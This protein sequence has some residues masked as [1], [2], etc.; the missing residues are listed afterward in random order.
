[1]KVVKLS[2]YACLV[3]AALFLTNAYGQKL[4]EIKFEKYELPNGL[5][6]ILHVDS[7]LP[8][9]SVNIWYHVGSQN[10]KPGRTG[11]AHLFEHMMFQGS[12][13]HNSGY[14]EP[15]ES[16]G[17]TANG[18]TTE[19][20]TNYLENIPSQYLE[21][22]LWLESDRM[23]YLVPAMTQE[24]LD[25]QRDV[26]KNERRERV[27]NQPY[28]KLEEILKSL[29]FPKDH[30]YSW[31]V[32]GSMAD[33]SAASRDDVIEFFQ[34]YYVPNNASL[35]IAGDFDPATAKQLVEKYFGPIPPGPAID[36]LQEWIPEF[37]GIRRAVAEDNV[38]LPQLTMAWHAPQVYK[39][40]DA[41]LD[42]LAAILGSG[43]NSRLYKSLVYD[44][45]IAQSVSVGLVS[46]E[47]GSVFHITATA[48]QGHSLDEIERAIDDEL[49]KL[50]VTGITREEFNLAQTQYEAYF[51]RSLERVG[52]FYGRA[53]L[54]NAYNIRLGDPGRFQWD[55]DRYL[56]TTPAKVMEFAR[57]YIDLNKRGIV[58][59]VP[60]TEVTAATADFDRSIK[61]APGPR[62]AFEPPM[63]QAAT[64]SNG[65]ELYVIERQD[66]PLVQVNLVIKSGFA[67]DPPQLPGLASLT[68]DLLD[69][70]TKSRTSLEISDEARSLGTFLAA[71]S[72]FDMTTVSINAMKKNLDQSLDLLADVTLHPVFPASELERL[73][74]MYLGRIALQAKDPGAQAFKAFYQ[75]L[76]GEG[77]PYAQP[78]TGTGTE[79][80]MNT[81]TLADVT[82]FYRNHYLPNNAVVIVVGDITL[83]A[84]KAELERAFKSWK[85]GTAPKVTI[86][87]PEV[88]SGT[89]I[90]IVDNPGAPQSMV[91]A[92]HLGLAR[93][94]SDYIPASLVNFILGGESIARLYM[95]LRQDKG[96][97]YGA[98][99]SFTSRVGTGAFVA[100]APVQTEVTKET[101]TELIKEIRGICGD[102]AISAEE[103]KASQSYL[104]EQLIQS[105]ETIGAMA[106]QVALQIINGLPMDYWRKYPDV[107]NAVD[108]AA[109]NAMARKLIHPDD[110][111]I[112]VYGDRAKVEAGLRELNVGEVVPLETAG[113]PE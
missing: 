41:E 21:T 4:P 110:L 56:T 11:F 49:R 83:D 106:G 27:E 13:H 8:M 64:L 70:G 97:T 48:Q 19:D 61:P 85:P 51:V 72:G 94:S 92:G 69:E 107:A 43:K 32:L 82:A 86:P 31:S 89:K 67:A 35:C 2:W 28:G 77:H 40:G 37:D 65:L 3:A 90:Y 18:S 7:T 95:N 104:T 46:Q 17:G 101:V 54:L 78:Y 81:V 58:S 14:F 15:L 71:N 38:N 63:P 6:V 47:L 79:A 36:R 10:E 57:R 74:K 100:Y 30:P 16:V 99:S 25:N 91:V 88:P 75:R 5:D 105:F 80:S 84:A 42:L 112:V 59:I 108:L 96:Y 103:L 24:R 60:R 53:D 52:D 29:M 20:R 76:Y 33:L 62:L 93:G 55:L 12:E 109:A 39:P 73:R 113:L 68:A 66:L 34:R 22:A 50:L 98:Y 26:V 45:Q 1:M 87:T 44:K 23:G 111:I 102:R 9:V